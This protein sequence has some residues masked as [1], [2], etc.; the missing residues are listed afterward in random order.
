MNFVPETLHMVFDMQPQPESCDNYI[1]Y[2]M[3]SA[4]MLPTEAE[5]FR[6]Q[7]NTNFLNVAGSSFCKA[8]STYI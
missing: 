4:C 3:F 7:K 1:R 8:A 2:N 6:I 5:T